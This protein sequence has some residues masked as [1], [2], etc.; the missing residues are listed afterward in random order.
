MKTLGAA[1][2]TRSNWSTFWWILGTVFMPLTIP[3]LLS[4]LLNQLR[5]LKNRDYLRDKVR[6]EKLALHLI[7]LIL[8]IF[9]M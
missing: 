8:F 3:Y 7:D 1:D 6:T 4:S 2:V 9:V 5:T